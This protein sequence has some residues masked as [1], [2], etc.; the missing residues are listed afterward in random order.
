MVDIVSI[1]SEEASKLIMNNKCKCVV[2]DVRNPD[3]YATGAIKNAINIPLQHFNDEK[4]KDLDTDIIIINCKSGMRS[5]NACEKLTD[6]FGKTIYSLE[7]GF[8]AWKNYGGAIQSTGCKYSIM[9]QVMMIAGGIVVF[10][11]LMVLVSSSNWVW[12]AGLIGAG[13]F[14][15]GITGYCG[16]AKLLSYMPWNKQ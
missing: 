15:A 1:S 11:S 10:A 8:I 13:L 3:E 5:C 7:G 4:I 2:I 14:F 12:L 16:M 9:Q 6:T